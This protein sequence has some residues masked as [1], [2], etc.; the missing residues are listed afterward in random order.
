MKEMTN[1]TK[2]II[3]AGAFSLIVAALSGL[4]IVLEESSVAKEISDPKLYC[5]V[6]SL[7]EDSLMVTVNYFSPNVD[8]H[9]VWKT[10]HHNY[11]KGMETFNVDLVQ[12]Y[13]AGSESQS[14]DLPALFSVT[15]GTEAPLG[16]IEDISGFEI[17]CNYELQNFQNYFLVKDFDCAKF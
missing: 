17:V 6:L 4:F 11:E 7:P 15:I 3:V 12:A 9:A 2:I 1:E 14:N 13:C 16:Q 8:S 10:G 5:T